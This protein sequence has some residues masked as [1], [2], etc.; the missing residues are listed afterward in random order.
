MPT[1]AGQKQGRDL[2]GLAKHISKEISKC[3][4]NSVVVADFVGLGETN[5]VEGHY[6]AMELSQSLEHHKK[7]FEVI[8]K[9]QLSAA[10]TNAKLSTKDLDATEILQHIGSLLQADAVVT[11]TVETAPARYAVHVAV[12]R[13][14]D[15]ALLASGDQSV[16]RPA[17]ADDLA[18]IDPNGSATGLAKAGVGGVGVPTCIVCPPPNYTDQARKAKIQGSVVLQVVVNQEGHIVKITVMRTSDDRLT[19]KAIEAVRK[20]QFKPATNKEGKPVAVSVPVEL[21]FRLY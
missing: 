11:G 18:L 12:R 13:V 17:Y 9:K 3:G 20:W 10:L 8:G 15:G 19:A 7:N 4:V 14:R 1:S 6:L 5:S 21:T 16:K 2:D